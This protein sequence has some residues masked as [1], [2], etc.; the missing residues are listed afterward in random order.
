MR[1]SNKTLYGAIL[2]TGLA[3][4]HSASVVAADKLTYYCSAQED[5][6]QLMAPRLRSRDRHQSRDDP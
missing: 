3:A 5:W 2:A 1:F 6:C 4:M